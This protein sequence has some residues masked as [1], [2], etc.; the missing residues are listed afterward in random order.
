MLMGPTWPM[1]KKVPYGWAAMKTFKK[2]SAKNIA[3][4]V[5]VKLIYVDS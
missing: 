3:N 1:K 2:K 5:V 4:A